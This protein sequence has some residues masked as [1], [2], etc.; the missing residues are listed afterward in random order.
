ML[1]H[2]E[3][4]GRLAQEPEIRYTQSGTPVAS[5]D[6]AVQVA[7]LR[8]KTPA[9]DYIPIVCWRERAEFCGRYLSKGTAR[10]SLRAGSPPVNG[11]ARKPDRTARPW[12]LWPQTFTSQTATEAT[13]M[14]IL[15]PPTMTDSWTYRTT[16]NFLLTNN[17]DRRTTA[18]QTG[19]TLRPNQKQTTKGGADSGMDP[20]SPTTERPPQG[21]G[22]LT[23]ST[24]NRLTCSAC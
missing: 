4:L 22:L 10:S 17:T 3:L 13:Q 16:D 15:S 14:A 23:S 11:R 1:N 19:G 21:A 2:V 7:E 24:L 9:P 12:K 20:N 18:G 8:T 6:L 5:F